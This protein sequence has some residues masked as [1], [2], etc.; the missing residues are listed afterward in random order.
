MLRNKDRLPIG[1][2]VV[3][4]KSL[5]GHGNDKGAG[6]PD[7]HEGDEGIITGHWDPANTDPDEL[8]V[9]FPYYVEF[10]RDGQSYKGLFAHE[11]LSPQK[12]DSADGVEWGLRES[13]GWVARMYDRADARET[14]KL[15]PN[16]VIVSRIVGP[17]RPVTEED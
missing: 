4:T 14:Q 6:F 11:V 3:F 7:L 16:A 5:P 9:P 1:T 17:W 2:P 15:H 13:N 10:H 12:T 8:A